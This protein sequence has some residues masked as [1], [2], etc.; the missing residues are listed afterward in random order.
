M[1]TLAWLT[2]VHLNFIDLDQTAAL[3]Q[4]VQ[5]HPSDAVVISGDLSEAPQLPV[6]LAMMAHY[7]RKPVYFV[8]GNH[9]YYHSSV[10]QVRAWLPDLLLV[11][12]TLTWLTDQTVIEI[13]PDTALVGH[14]GWADGRCGQADSPLLLN[15]FNLIDE[16]RLPL[17]ADRFAQ[18]QHFSDQAADHVRQMLLLALEQYAHVLV[19]THV[20]PFAES[21]PSDDPMREYYLPFYVSRIMGDVLLEM[22]E[23]YP[24]RQL[25]VLCGHTHHA[26]STRLRPNLHVLVGQAEYGRPRLQP[27]IVYAP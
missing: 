6:V 14:D 4:R 16:L 24:H 7:I 5:R 27:H 15:D 20:P 25:L 2:D 10:K 11:H 23:R 8:L 21:N 3:L 12:P 9:D 1:K 13:T 19:V 17:S 18:M 22:A 26:T